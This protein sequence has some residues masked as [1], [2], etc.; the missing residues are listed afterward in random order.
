[1][2][3]S[4]ILT[5]GWILMGKWTMLIMKHGS[6]FTMEMEYFGFIPIHWTLCYG[7]IFYDM[8]YK[9]NLQCL[10]YQKEENE[11]IKT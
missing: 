4:M 11:N 9:W 7:Q 2:N 1:M 3:S 6:D 8:Y 10:K 5:N